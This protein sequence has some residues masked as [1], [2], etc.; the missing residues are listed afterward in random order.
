MKIFNANNLWDTLKTNLGS[1]RDYSPNSKIVVAVRTPALDKAETSGIVGENSNLQFSN[2]FIYDPE[3]HK[4]LVSKISEIKNSAA[5]NFEKTAF[6]KKLEQFKADAATIKG[7]IT[8][9]KPKVKVEKP[10]KHIDEEALL[11]DD[12]DDEDK[13]A[14]KLE[15]QLA[16]KNLGAGGSPSSSKSK[17]VPSA[18]VSNQKEN[19]NKLM[20]AV[21]TFASIAK[22]YASK[23]MIESVE[24][25]IEDLNSYRGDTLGET[26][27][28]VTVSKDDS[29][30]PQ[31][32]RAKLF[33]AYVAIGNI[34]TDEQFKNAVGDTSAYKDLNKVFLTKPQLQ[35]IAQD[36]NKVP[37]RN[38][39]FVERMTGADEFAQQVYKYLGEVVQ[40]K[41]NF[42]GEMG[43]F[44]IT[45]TNTGDFVINDEH[46]SRNSLDDRYRQFVETLTQPGTNLNAK[47][48]DFFQK[49]VPRED[50]GA[51]LNKYICLRFLKM[52]T[53][54]LKKKNLQDIYQVIDF[55]FAGTEF[56]N[57][58][59]MVVKNGGFFTPTIDSVANENIEVD[60]GVTIQI[61]EVKPDDNSAGEYYAILKYGNEPEI[62]FALDRVGGRGYSNHIIKGLSTNRNAVMQDLYKHVMNIL[63]R[64]E[65]LSGRAK[66]PSQSKYKD[67]KY[68]NEIVS[69]LNV[70]GKMTGAR[71][72]YLN[73]IRKFANFT[74]SEGHAAYGDDPLARFTVAVTYKGTVS[75]FVDFSKTSD[76]SFRITGV[77]Y[78]DGDQAMAAR[79]VNALNNKTGE[80]KFD[81]SNFSN[82]SDMPESK[83]REIYKRITDFYT[84][85]LSS[86]INGIGKTQAPAVAPEG[87]N[88]P[89]TQTPTQAPVK[90]QF[91]KEQLLAIYNEFND[92]SDKEK[93]T[94]AEE[95]RLAELTNAISDNLDQMREIVAI[96][97][98][99]DF[100][101]MEKNIEH[102]D[103]LSN[104]MPSYQQNQLMRKLDAL[105]DK[106]ETASEKDKPTIQT[107][108]DRITQALQERGD[109]T[110]YRNAHD[111][112]DELEDKI[113]DIAT[114]GVKHGNQSRQ[115]A[116]ILLENSPSRE[117]YKE[118]ARFN[119][120]EYPHLK[121]YIE[122]IYSPD[123][124]RLVYAD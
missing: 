107:E 97:H 58:F 91:S 74:N 103:R 104:A 52:I 38:A 48:V 54:D 13:A 10:A 92:L 81:T 62:K 121:S 111:N 89:A 99:S 59:K 4:E 1:E 65:L 8:G 56:I 43:K 12:D 46:V 31:S 116:I 40:T 76:T 113:I 77:H 75:I 45:E 68:F 2:R 112:I 35:A 105:Y 41:G 101:E 30:N 119:L 95:K 36:I 71:M 3:T 64:N 83:R 33:S 29:H 27:R 51:E 96:G 22:D 55:E 93:R 123:F 69:S 122:N 16:A 86:V 50:M 11:N 88:A 102:A 85:F 6:G 37:N 124:V 44:K 100:E 73:L 98:D 78:A 15:Q 84:N 67:S 79:L 25:A 90:K 26:Y 39:D 72:K 28:R 114:H 21:S 7:Y 49:L 108:I 61:Y 120:D 32:A 5:K 117:M 57:L 87:V 18:V 110:Q 63:I 47:I 80:Y 60:N 20:E 14:L 42:T 17:S 19:A 82:L 70:A 115:A 9:E 66:D 118:N 53:G 34:L 23:T 24:R 94:P 109:F 106:M